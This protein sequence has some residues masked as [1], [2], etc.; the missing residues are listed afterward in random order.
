[1][2]EFAIAILAGEEGFHRGCG[3]PLGSSAEFV[4]LNRRLTSTVVELDIEQLAGCDVNLDAAVGRGPC[5]DGD[6][7]RKIRYRCGSHTRSEIGLAPALDPSRGD[8]ADT[9]TDC[10]R[11]ETKHRAGRDSASK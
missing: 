3:N 8:R 9:D 5:G 6:N 4:L 10:I 7:S 1:M 11:L 2:K